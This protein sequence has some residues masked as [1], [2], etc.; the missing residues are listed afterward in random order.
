MINLDEQLKDVRTVAIAGHVRPDG[1]AFGSCMG[2]YLFLKEYYPKIEAHVYLENNF[3][4]A[5]TFVTC[6]DEI[7]TSYPDVDPVDLFISLDVSSLDRFG[8]ALKYF[9]ASKRTLVIDHHISNPCFG[10]V[11]E[12]QPDAS[13]TSELVTLLIGKERLNRTIAEP[14][15]MGIVHDTGVFQYSCTSS[16]TMMVGGWLMDTGI[17]FSRIVEKTFFTKTHAQA[18]VIGKALSESI[19]MLDGKVIF[20]VIHKKDMD[21]YGVGPQDLSAIVSLLRE[22]EGT[23]VA[24]FLYQSGSRE[25]KVSLRSN[26][27]VDVAKIAMFFQGGGHVK[28][29]GCTVSGGVHDVVNNIVAKVEEQLHAL[30][31]S[32]N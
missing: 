12:I 7:V 32:G 20:S 31:E 21:F 5:F 25:Y 2:M 22:V 17:N 18:H 9:E 27:K 1:D 10:D 11:N 28:A 13:S 4:P 19:L 16:R 26:G 3:S 14:L 8:E 23:E 30:E 6:S 24:I 29:A 15:Y